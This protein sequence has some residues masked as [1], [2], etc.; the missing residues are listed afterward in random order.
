MTLLLVALAGG[1]GTALRFLVNGLLQP[2]PMATLSVNL[3]GSLAIGLLFGLD[4]AR[5]VEPLLRTVVAAGFLGGLTTFSGFAL[6]LFHLLRSGT[7]GWAAIYFA[8]QNFGCL[9]AVLAG[10]AIGR[11][12]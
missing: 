10:H 1:L 8:A 4:H 3:A 5:G 7:A 6:D 9:G 11:S 2:L 12:V